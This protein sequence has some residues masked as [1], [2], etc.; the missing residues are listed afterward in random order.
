MDVSDL[1]FNKLIGLQLASSE[2]G[3]QTCLPDGQQYTNHLGT[4]HA[5]AMLAVAEAGSGAFLAR[6]FSGYASVVPVV[7][8]LEAKFRKPGVGQVS[9]RCVI[10]PD[11]LSKWTA[12]LNERGRLSAPIPVEVVDAAGNVVLSATVEWFI[13]NVPA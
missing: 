1:P 9:A 3:F 13:S 6:E 4:V 8:R 5:S 2:S 7:R 11:T 12:E 10:A